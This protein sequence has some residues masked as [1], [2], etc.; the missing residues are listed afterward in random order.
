MCFLFDETGGSTCMKGDG[1]VVGHSYCSRSGTKPK[2]RASESDTHFT[3]MTVT[4]LTDE[5]VLCVIIF[6]GEPR[7]IKSTNANDLSSPGYVYEQENNPILWLRPDT[8]HLRRI[9]CPLN[10]T[11]LM[12]RIVLEKGTH[13]REVW[14]V[15]S[16][17][18]PYLQCVNEV[19]GVA[20]VERS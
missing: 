16:T 20:P 14:C 12:F 18:R 5:P 10:I 13:S 15:N 1:H 7:T 11:K 3:S 8:I 9:C 4:S 19:R 17:A 2:M 6:K